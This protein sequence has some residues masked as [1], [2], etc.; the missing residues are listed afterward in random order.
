MMLPCLL[1][2][3][4]CVKIVFPKKDQVKIKSFVWK[5]CGLMFFET[6]Y[7]TLVDNYF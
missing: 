5:H 6:A 1:S 3:Y 4:N 7:K 2:L